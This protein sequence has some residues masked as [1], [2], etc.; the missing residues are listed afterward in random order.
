MKKIKLDNIEELAEIMHEDAHDDNCVTA[1]LFYDEAI[2]LMRE[3]LCYDCV[4]PEAFEIMP[5][6]WD[7]YDKEY[8]VQLSDDMML[9]VEPACHDGIYYA[10]GADYFYVDSNADSKVLDRIDSA[11]FLIEFGKGDYDCK[12]HDECKTNEDTDDD[13][14]DKLISNAKVTRDD[15]GITKRY[16][17]DL[18]LLLDYLFGD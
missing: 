15:D 9:A 10:C 2:E 6:D 16:E 3:L 17:L 7:G 1:I 14:L 13:K 12:C 4:I 5:K 18:D 11:C 8:F